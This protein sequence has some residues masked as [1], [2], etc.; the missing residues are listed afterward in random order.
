MKS[1]ALMLVLALP[2]LVAPHVARSQCCSMPMNDG[3][4]ARSAHFNERKARKDIDRV[5]SREESRAIL[6]EALMA[7]GDFTEAFIGRMMESSRWRA[8]AEKELAV[9][10]GEGRSR[11]KGSVSDGGPKTP[12]EERRVQVSVDGEGFHPAS[13]NVPARTPLRL[14]VTRTSNNT[15]AKEIVIPSLD[16]TGRL[17]LNR[18]V[19]IRIPP[20]DRGTVTFACGMNMYQGQ[21]VVQ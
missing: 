3:D 10:R 7:D 21:L 20:Q 1:Q 9:S 17:P 14:V 8:M 15:C 19:E 2:L 13:I 11:S 6:M 4:H 12:A 5:L 18:P 16:E